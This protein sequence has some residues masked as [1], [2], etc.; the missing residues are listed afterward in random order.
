VG[1]VILS[2]QVDFVLELGVVLEDHGEALGS[3][4]LLS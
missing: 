1:V 3:V 4:D 2:F